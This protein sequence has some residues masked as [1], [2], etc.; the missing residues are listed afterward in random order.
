VVGLTFMSEPCQLSRSSVNG[1]SPATTPMPAVGSAA[2]VGGEAAQAPI[3]GVVDQGG[4]I[5]VPDADG[6]LRPQAGRPQR[7][8]R[9]QRV[10]GDEADRLARAHADA[11]PIQ[12]FTSRIC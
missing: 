11:H 4:A 6:P 7:P 12:A 1:R 8:E 10:R 2:A 5:P 3:G 9:D